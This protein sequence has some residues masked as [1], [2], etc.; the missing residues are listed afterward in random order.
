VFTGSNEGTGEVQGDA[1]AA[2]GDAER[3]SVRD[4]G[5][6]LGVVIAGICLIVGLGLFALRWS[7]R[8]FGEG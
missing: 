7:S 1:G 4:D 3:L 8:R 6:S 2:A 5:L